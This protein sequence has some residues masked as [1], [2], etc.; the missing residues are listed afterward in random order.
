MGN[1]CSQPENDPNYANVCSTSIDE[2]YTIPG[3]CGDGNECRYIGDEWTDAGTIVDEEQCPCYGRKVVCQRTSFD[4]DQ[5]QCCL[6]DFSGTQNR[7]NCFVGD[8]TCAPENRGPTQ[9]GCRTLFSD[10]CGQTAT[11]IDSVYMQ[12]WDTPD[13]YCEKTLSGNVQNQNGILNPEG[14]RWSQSQMSNVLNAYFD[15][16][17]GIQPP[18]REGSFQNELY[19]ICMKY[20][21]ACDI[22]LKQ[23]CGNYTRLDAEA[24]VNIGRFCGCHLNSTAYTQYEDQFGIPFNCDPV[25]SRLDTIP[26]VNND[27][28]TSLCEGA[29]CIIDDITLSLVDSSVSGDVNFYQACGGCTG[30]ESCTCIISGVDIIAV[31]S[32]LGGVNLEQVCGSEPKCYTADTEDPTGPAIP[33]SCETGEIVPE[34]PSEE[35]SNPDYNKLQLIVIIIAGFLLIVAIVVVIIIVVYTK[36]QKVLYELPSGTL[37]DFIE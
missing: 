34:T 3:L 2:Q 16:V 30:S 9:I 26:S 24:N 10:T 21:S 29:I 25:C 20:P 37:T 11:P 33:V 12:Y 19:A 27:Y 18:G 1:G 31:E 8:T 17:G 35:E 23:V 22:G 7:N 13:E 14:I 36:K 32:G 5:R 28:T 15:N 6:Q 4:A